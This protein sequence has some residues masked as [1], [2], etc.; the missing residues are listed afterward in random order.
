MKAQ[1][2]FLIRRTPAVSFDLVAQPQHLSRFTAAG[3]P[4]SPPLS[5]EPTSASSYCIPTRTSSGTDVDA[6]Y[7]GAPTTPQQGRVSLP[8]IFVF[9]PC[10]EDSGRPPNSYCAFRASEQHPSPPT[11]DLAKLNEALE[12]LERITEDLPKFGR[13]P[14]V[15]LDK[16]AV[17]P[18]R[19]LSVDMPVPGQSLLE[20]EV[21]AAAALLESSYTTQHKSKSIFGVTKTIKDVLKTKSGAKPTYT[22]AAQKLERVGSTP[23]T[24]QFANSTLEVGSP[25]VYHYTLRSERQNVVQRHRDSK[26]RDS[27][28]KHHVLPPQQSAQFQSF[29]GFNG[30]GSTLN[31]SPNEL[32]PSMD[33][34]TPRRKRGAGFSKLFRKTKGPRLWT[35][36][37]SPSYVK[38][39]SRQSIPYPYSWAKWEPE[40]PSTPPLSPQNQLPDKLYQHTTSA[41]STQ[42][43]PLQ[44]YRNGKEK[45]DTRVQPSDADIPPVP[46]LPP[47]FASA[48]TAQTNPP[49]P[50]PFPLQSAFE[51]K[52]RPT[53]RTASYRKPVPDILSTPPRTR[54]SPVDSGWP[55][56]SPPS[57]IPANPFSSPLSNLRRAVQSMSP[58]SVSQTTGTPSSSTALSPRA[59][60]ERFSLTSSKRSPAHSDD[61]NTVSW[62]WTSDDVES[63]REVPPIESRR[64]MMQ[65]DSLHFSD[66]DFDVSTF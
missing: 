2:R 61:A 11:P 14:G 63:S 37:D 26:G 51:L 31:P 39:T 20:T 12:Y 17:L 13:L 42:S 9:T 34:G 52:D 56:R 43:L 36:G 47:Q 18:K 45:G 59:L 40:S 21:A 60:L 10:D 38:A 4:P 48:P 64:R 7:Y 22:G 58:N 41:H 44:K 3:P 65:L 8:D 29:F 53:R 35:G 15:P 24:G 1:S 28:S 27:S 55:G 49:P 57:S 33:I 23:R 19:K 16:V 46:P 54:E 6:D 66:L 25:H 62:P 32:L 30:S 5:L 50:P